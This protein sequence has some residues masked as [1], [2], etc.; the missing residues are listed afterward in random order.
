MP[1]KRLEIVR[2]IFYPTRNHSV[3]VRQT[4]KGARR[5]ELCPDHLGQGANELRC[6]RGAM[7]L[8]FRVDELADGE[9][10]GGFEALDC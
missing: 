10:E 1:R 5:T 7:A 4:R 2:R 3:S 9:P 8:R 6:C